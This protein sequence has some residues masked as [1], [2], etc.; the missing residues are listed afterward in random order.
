MS[1]HIVKESAI[2]HF[3]LKTGKWEGFGTI[4]ILQTGAAIHF[5]LDW[6]VRVLE[7]G[8]IEIAQVTCLTETE[9]CWQST[10]FIKDIQDNKFLAELYNPLYGNFHGNGM[11][12]QSEISWRLYDEEERTVC[13]INQ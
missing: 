6:K 3:L 8:T 1:N 7:N 9:E 4:I 2:D 5:T 13:C 12:S 10:H 11:L